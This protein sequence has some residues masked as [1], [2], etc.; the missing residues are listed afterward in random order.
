MKK[1]FHLTEDGTKELKLEHEQRTAERMNIAD[2][3]KT[4]REF[5]DLAENAEYASA[6]HEQ[7]QNEVRI[8]EIEHILANSDLIKAGK[9]ANS[10]VL[11]SKVSLESDA[12]MKVQF[13]V[14]GS[15]EANP[16]EGKISDESPIGKAL[17]GKKLGDLVAIVTPSE[18]KKYTIAAIA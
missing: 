1:I 12:G 3:I 11:G 15:V 4:A 2:R 5:G 18:T 6:K 8:G 9:S 17:I 16:L 14:V 10:V 7:E 13:M